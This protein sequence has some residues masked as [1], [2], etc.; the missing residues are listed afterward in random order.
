M[1]QDMMRHHMMTMHGG[2]PQGQGISIH[3]GMHGE[4]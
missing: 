1:M 3:G 2:E 4:Q